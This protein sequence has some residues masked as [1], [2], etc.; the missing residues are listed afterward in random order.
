MKILLIQVKL[1]FLE[2]IFVKI[3][4][5]RFKKSSLRNKNNTEKM[6]MNRFQKKRQEKEAL[7]ELLDQ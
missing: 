7:I 1:F 4:E 3:L 6:L 2:K 5:K